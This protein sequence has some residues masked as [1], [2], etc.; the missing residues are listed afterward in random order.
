MV[1]SKENKYDHVKLYTPEQ[2]PGL[3]ERA[4]VTKER[5]VITSLAWWTSIGY[6]LWPSAVE[7]VLNLMYK[8]EPEAAPTGQVESLT[9]KGDKEQLKKLG[10]LFSGAL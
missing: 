9:A 2:S 1:V 7:G 3:I 5:K 4:I 10:T 6:F 8:L